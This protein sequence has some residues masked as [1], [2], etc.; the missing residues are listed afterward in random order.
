[1]RFEYILGVFP[2]LA[3]MSTA[4]RMTVHQDCGSS[5]DRQHSVFFTGFDACNMDA[6]DGQ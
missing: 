2:S 1:M 5:S 6:G 3:A 4:D